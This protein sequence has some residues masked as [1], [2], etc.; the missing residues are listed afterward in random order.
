MLVPSFLTNLHIAPMASFGF[1]GTQI[2]LISNP[3][4]TL[5]PIADGMQLKDKILVS[6]NNTKYYFIF[7]LSIF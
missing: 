4:L 6:W 7:H 5:E 2:E 1:L 3:N